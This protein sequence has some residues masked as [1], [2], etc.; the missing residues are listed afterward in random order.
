MQKESTA[1]VTAYRRYLSE[2]KDKA[3][4]GI[5][6][7]ASGGREGK[8]EFEGGD[9]RGETEKAAQ[10][11]RTASSRKSRYITSEEASSSETNKHVK[12]GGAREATAILQ[13]VDGQLSE[14]EIR[15]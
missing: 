13:M 6:V 10:R 9:E 3:A 15:R 5:A 2:K 12:S 11:G 4:T 8:L 7:V 14:M 1:L